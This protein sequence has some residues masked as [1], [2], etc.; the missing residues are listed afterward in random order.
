MHLDVSITQKAYRLADGGARN[1]FD[2]FT[3]QLEAGSVVA[4]LG[5]S[6]CGKSSL[7][8]MIS[9]LDRDFSG[10]IGR[11]AGRISM[12]FQEPRLLAWRNVEDNLRLVAPELSQDELKA[13]LAAFELDVHGQDY[14][15]QLS[16]GLARRAALARAFA[17]KPDLLL[18]DEPFASLDRGLHDRLRDNLAERIAGRAMTVIVATHDIEDALRLADQIIFMGGAPARIL[19]IFDIEA[20]REARGPLMPQLRAQAQQIEDEA[21][22]KA[23]ARLV[24]S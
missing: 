19:N 7:L 11:P 23:G 12:A 8:R 1:V 9:G 22:A 2:N 16:L 21:I 20:P 13:L 17:V 3:L 14:P 6:G 5:P 4:L 10:A 18:L 24:T 15:G